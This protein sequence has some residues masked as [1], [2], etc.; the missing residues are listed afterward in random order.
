MASI[1]E[2]QYAI[3]LV[4][5]GELKLNEQKPVVHPGSHQILVKT[6]AVGLCFSDLKLLAQF[7]GHVR[8]SEILTGLSSEILADI[9]SYVPGEQATVPGHEVVCR[10]VEV[11]DKVK[12]YKVGDRFI[13]Q[14]D[15]RTL[16]TT[17][18]NGAFGYNF[19]GGLQ[20]FIVLDER[21]IGDPE[22]PEGYMIR[23]DDSRGDSAV[24]LVEP[25][26]CVE[27]SYA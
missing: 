5:P 27:N 11:G 6:E 15:Y 21:V 17:G 18:S 14:A 3:Q 26:A 1:P 12:H 25:W 4:G 16:K 22:E 9:P 10:V 7:N 20:E 2:T 8:K 19:E 23:V 24:A 13:V